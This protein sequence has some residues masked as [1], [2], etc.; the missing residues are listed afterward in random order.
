MFSLNVPFIQ[1][2][3]SLLKLI[4]NVPNDYSKKL[5]SLQGI[6]AVN[7]VMRMRKSFFSDQTY[8]LNVCI[9]N[10]PVLAIVEHTNFMNK[11]VKNKVPGRSV[12]DL[13]FLK[14]KIMRIMF[15]SNIRAGKPI[16]AVTTLFRNIFL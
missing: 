15:L 7:I 8:W 5:T 9:K 13:L 16:P 11:T 4:H 10:S 12:G 1:N 3:L 6:G 2:L 14:Y